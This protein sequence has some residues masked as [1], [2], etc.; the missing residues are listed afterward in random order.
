MR[1][2]RQTVIFIHGLR[3]DSHGLLDIANELPQDRYEAIT[4]DLPG[5]G[6]NP[7][8]SNSTTDSYA[9]WLH[10]YIEE[11]KIRNPIIVGHSMGSIIAS[12]YLSKYPDDTSSKAVFLSPI[13]RSGPKRLKNKITCVLIMVGLKLL[14][15][16]LRYKLLKSHFI[17][18][19][20][21]AKRANGLVISVTLFN[22][23]AK[24]M[25]FPL[26]ANYVDM[27]LD[28]RC[29]KAPMFPTMVFPVQAPC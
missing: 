5:Y 28:S 18:V 8:L 15:S 2:K 6:N 25:A 10:K 16:K 1:S 12:A 24:R 17:L 29:T 20:N 27:V 26:F 21:I 11:K 19:W 14:V 23:I 9:D 4:L 22:N 13:F 3:G 7:A